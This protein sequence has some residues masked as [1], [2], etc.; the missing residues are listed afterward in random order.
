MAETLTKAAELARPAREFVKGFQAAL[1]IVEAGA[2]AEGHVAR[3]QAEAAAA[4][5]AA[6]AA[7]EGLAAAVADTEAAQAEAVTKAHDEADRARILAKTLRAQADQMRQTMDDE[8]AQFGR[9]IRAIKSDLE[10]AQQA[11]RDGIARADGEATER[12]AVLAQEISE[13]ERAKTAL[14]GDLASLRRDYQGVV[15]AA[16]RLG[17]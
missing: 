11:R 1:E 9:E 6:Q 7:R 15:E 8:R 13:L 16:Q 17:R 12:K 2:R 5:S 10:R 3:L 4:Q 14:E